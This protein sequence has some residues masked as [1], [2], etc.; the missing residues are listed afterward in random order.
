VAEL[1]PPAEGKTSWDFSLIDPM[2]SDFLAATEGHPVI[3]NFNSIPQWMYK[4]EKSVA[5]P[6]GPEQVTWEYEQGTELRDP[7]FKQVADDYARLLSWYTQ[8]GFTDEFGQRHESGHHYSIPYWE[9]LNEPE[10]E[11]HV[12]PEIYTHLYDAVVAAVRRVQ[13]DIKFFGM[14]LAFP[15]QSPGYVE[16]FPDHKS[17]PARHPAGLYFLSLLRGA[18]ARPNSGNPAVHFLCSGRRL[19]QGCA[20]CRIG[21]KAA[22][23]RNQ[24]PH[25]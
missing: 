2:T 5:Y 21:A 13:P 12:S 18:D 16:Y 24:D 9:V 11:H 7:S 10:L 3:L 6:A 14:A 15:G 23:A 1:D 4:T 20:I 22:L 17:H 8:G 19:P 25:R